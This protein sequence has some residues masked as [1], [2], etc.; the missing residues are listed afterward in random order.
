MAGVRGGVGVKSRSPNLLNGGLFALGLT[1]GLLLTVVVLIAAD[2]LNLIPF[3]DSAFTG[4]II[5]A[6]IAGLIGILGQLLLMAQSEVISDRARKAEERVKLEKLL[7]RIVRTLSVL[8]Q[9]KSLIESSQP[10]DLITLYS[11]PP[12]TKPLRINNI[13][14]RIPEE[15]IAVALSLSDRKLF[16]LLN[17]LDTILANF[18]WI[19]NRY[20]ASVDRFLENI[21]KGSE[22]KF[23]DGAYSGHGRIDIR[24]Y[25]EIEDIWKHYIDSTYGGLVVSKRLGDM[26]VD[27]LS[28]RHNVNLSFS[29]RITPSDWKVL[30]DSVDVGEFELD[31]EH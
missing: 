31:M 6:L 24:E 27:Y 20:E 25:H 15:L 19:H 2:I 4:A 14:D 30:F 17:V 13:P 23:E 22:I 16:N 9:V 8:A 12:I 28:N 1:V 10:R 5:G 3:E 21:K 18:A 29:D 26:V 7:N 11:L